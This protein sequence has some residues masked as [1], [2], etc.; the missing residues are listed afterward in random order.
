MAVVDIKRAYFYAP[1]KR[2]IYIELPPEDIEQGDEDKVGLLKMSLCGIRD[3]AKNWAA[4]Y[5][6]FFCSIGFTLGR[7]SPCNFR[8]AE[9]DIDLT[10]HGDDFLV[11][12]SKDKLRWVIAMMKSKYD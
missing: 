3:A 8:H 5:T 4:A 6:E 9:K 7:A 12:G 11:V 10:V 1:A 2:T